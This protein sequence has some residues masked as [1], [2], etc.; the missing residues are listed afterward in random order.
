[1]PGQLTTAHAPQAYGPPPTYGHGSMQQQ[2]FGQQGGYG[3]A[4]AFQHLGPPPSG[5]QIQE[6][7]NNIHTLVRT[8]E[9]LETLISEERLLREEQL[10]LE[11]GAEEEGEIEGRHRGSFSGEWGPSSYSHFQHGGRHHGRRGHIGHPGGHF[12]GGDLEY[13]ETGHRGGYGEEYEGD[14]NE[15]DSGYLSTGHHHLPHHQ[16]H[17]G[18]MRAPL[19]H[20]VHHLRHHPHHHPHHFGGH[21]GHRH[22]HIR[23]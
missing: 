11:E 9:D 15:G 16:G 1:M 17:I 8:V 13:P 23:R 18:H 3:S 4:P 6:L 14:L 19:H 20:P 22:H 12:G 10:E 7:S 5:A 21:L 2:H